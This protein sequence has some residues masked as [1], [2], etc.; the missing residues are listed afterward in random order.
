MHE[1]V[2]MRECYLQCLTTVCDADPTPG[3]DVRVLDVFVR[4]QGRT[5]IKVGSMSPV[6]EK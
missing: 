2:S 6:E 3:A 5:R 1:Y 4:K